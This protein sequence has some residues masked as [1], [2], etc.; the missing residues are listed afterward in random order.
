MKERRRL[1]NLSQAKLAEKVNTST[2]YIGM[3]ELCRKFPSPDMLERI[4]AALEIDSPELFSMKAFPSQ[5]IRE[6]QQL[7]LS[8]ME[9]V[10]AGRLKD[11]NTLAKD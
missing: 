8:D 3:I 10:I 1:L 4:A 9:Q 6:F 11:M 7:V 5:T 2:H